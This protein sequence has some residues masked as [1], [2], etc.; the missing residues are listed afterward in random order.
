MDGPDDCLSEVVGDKIVLAHHL[1]DV[2]G[3]L[4]NRQELA[5]LMPGTRF[6]GIGHGEHQRLVVHKCGELVAF[7]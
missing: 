4:G 3:E 2:S 1:A 6:S 5:L 7:Q